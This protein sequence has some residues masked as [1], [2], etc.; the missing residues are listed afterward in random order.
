MAVDDAGRDVLAAPVDGFLRQTRVRPGDSV[1]QGDVLVEL[2]DQDLLLEK[3]R[4]E[5]ELA[6]HQNN[7][8]LALGKSDRGQFAV[9]FARAAEAKAQ[10]ELVE[11]QLARAQ[12]VSPIDGLVIQGDLTQMVGAPVKRGDTLLTVAPRDQYRIIVE[13]DERDHVFPVDPQLGDRRSGIR[14]RWIETACHVL[15]GSRRQ[16]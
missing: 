7:F 1:K 14:Y 6:R 16:G 3:K 12:V 10:L 11:S 9:N 2:A 8:S 13:V 15:H 4:W 5:S